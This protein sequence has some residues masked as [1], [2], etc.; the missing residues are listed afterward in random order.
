[1]GS[2]QGDSAQCNG[3]SQ[4]SS[5][6][7]H[8][9]PQY[10]FPVSQRAP[11]SDAK[12]GL[13]LSAPVRF[14]T[15][16]R[17]WAIARIAATA[18]LD[19]LCEAMFL[20]TIAGVAFA[21]ADGADHIDAPLG[22]TLSVTMA[23]GLAVALVVMRVG[24][25]CWTSRQSADLA[26]RV[27]ADLRRRLSRAF[28]VASWEVQQAERSGSLQEFLV[29]YTTQANALMTNVVQ[30]AMK[31]ATLVSMAG[32][33]IV[34][35]PVGAIVLFAVVGILTSVFRPLRSMIRGQARAANAATMNFATSV[36]E[37]SE[38]G[39]ELHVFNVQDAADLRLGA[40]IERARRATARVTFLVGISAPLF[41]GLAYFAAIGA[42]AVAVSLSATNLTSF[43]AVVLVMLR[44]LTYGQAIQSARTGVSRSI[45]AIEE[46]QRRL[47]IFEGCQV[48]QSGQGIDRIGALAVEGVSFGYQPDVPVLR[49]VSFKVMPREIIGIVGPS[50]AG[51][52]TLV[53]LLLGLR[54]PDC[55][56]ILAGGRDISDIDPADWARK[57]TFVPQ[58]AHLI[59]GTIAENIR[60][61]R[62]GVSQDG[63]ERAARLAH[64]H[65][66]VKA[67]PEGYDR[68]VGPRGGRLSGGQQQRLCIARA[69]VERPDVLILDEPTSSLDVRSEH[70]IRNTL[71]ELKEHMTVIVIAHRLSTLTICDRIMVIGDGE[72]KDFDTPPRLEQSSSFYREALALSGM[73]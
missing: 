31:G 19:G 38:L 22:R 21:V 1:M 20:V 41:S 64:L 51:K 39:L 18:F 11:A 53:Q 37:V 57:V 13:S 45:P 48:V 29:G 65:E 49:D 33:A 9:H 26:T 55:G 32:T 25:A 61:L 50:G 72:V 44:S 59:A 62:D 27:V 73:R 28:L 43:G 60:F 71:L 67:F 58:V 16:G 7:Y 23:L 34:F 40:A 17:G 5:Q 14:V 3:S 2:K 36:N 69:L 12:P 56:R 46:L 8:M 6:V 15:R 54:R 47:E 35:D 24:F 4:V 68:E 63:I 10:Y 66:D 52:S 30:G 42:L 70:L